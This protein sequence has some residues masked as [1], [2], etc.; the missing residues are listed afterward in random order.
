M[1]TTFYYLFL[2]CIYN[3]ALSGMEFLTNIF[4]FKQTA[5]N[6]EITI[7]AKNEIYKWDN[8]PL[9]KDALSVD[10]REYTRR[11]K[12]RVFLSSNWT[13]PHNNYHY[14][15]YNLVKFYCGNRDKSI[16][17]SSYLT[18]K[19]TKDHEVELPLPKCDDFFVQQCEGPNALHHD[20][21]AR[22]LLIISG[23]KIV[24]TSVRNNGII[25]R[26]TPCLLA[27]TNPIANKLDKNNL[28]KLPY[29]EIPIIGLGLQRQKKLNNIHQLATVLKDR[30]GM[31][32]I[33]KIN[34]SNH[35]ETYQDYVLKLTYDNQ[36]TD[37]IMDLSN[38]N[39]AK[40][41]WITDSLLVLLASKTREKLFIISLNPDKKCAYAYEQ[42]F[43]SYDYIEGFGLDLAN[44]KFC[45]VL[46]SKENKLDL[47]HINLSS[48]TPIYKRI[49]TIKHRVTTSSTIHALEDRCMITQPSPGRISRS[50]YLITLPTTITFPADS[51]K[52]N[53]NAKKFTLQQGSYL[54]S[55][56]DVELPNLL[57]QAANWLVSQQKN[58]ASL[59][60]LAGL[61]ALQNTY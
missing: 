6:Y 47:L 40:I 19:H 38:C 37:Q 16:Y 51:I 31:L 2:L 17:E 36:P 55:E 1:K 9:Q 42:R 25:W 7:H 56:Y 13:H 20:E 14:H 5:G 57:Q 18:F 61:I 35:Q 10:Y 23:I 44:P 30:E 15:P 60:M 22:A 45:Y 33:Y 11:N 52:Q 21:M 27:Y 48:P 3:P 49:Q 50:I 29:P 26:Y 32:R 43:K 24:G 4:E 34:P 41:S 28:I 39:Y 58:V 59:C 53:S 8:V 54:V 12:S 46:V